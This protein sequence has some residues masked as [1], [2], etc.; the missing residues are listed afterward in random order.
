MGTRNTLGDLNLHLFEQMERLN[1]DSLTD[2]QLDRELRRA[3]AMSEI[4]EQIVKTGDLAYKTMK[5]MYDSG[6]EITAPEML[7]M[8]N[9]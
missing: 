6:H 4:A 9:D 1:D 3:D 8:K 2:E 5:L 7:E